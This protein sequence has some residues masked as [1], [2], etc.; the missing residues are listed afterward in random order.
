MFASNLYAMNGNDQQIEFELID[1]SY[2]LRDNIV[3]DTSISLLPSYT[4][5]TKPGPI[6]H[7]HVVLATCDDDGVHLNQIDHVKKLISVKAFVN[8]LR[9]GQ[10]VK[11]I[12]EITT[13][14]CQTAPASIY[15][16]SLAFKRGEVKNKALVVALHTDFC[17]RRQFSVRAPLLISNMFLL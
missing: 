17:S 5:G 3:T 9:E 10:L 16:G 6:E 7:T 13:L 4:L 14:V 12:N 2:K 8:Q 15:F 11:A 1:H